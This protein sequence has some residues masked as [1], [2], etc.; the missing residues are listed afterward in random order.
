MDEELAFLRRRTDPIKRV[1]SDLTERDQAELLQLLRLWYFERKRDWE[2][3]E[4]LH[5][6]YMTIRRRR[7]TLVTLTAFAIFGNMIGIRKNRTQVEQKVNKN[8]EANVV[9]S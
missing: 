8:E 5:W 4:R 7:K 6:S 1:I 2:I 9:I 3:S